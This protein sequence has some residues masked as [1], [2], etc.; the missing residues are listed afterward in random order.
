MIFFSV[1]LIEL[2]FHILNY[3]PYFIELFVSV[4]L[5]L[6]QEFITVLF[7][8]IQVF[9][10]VSFELFQHI[11]SCSLFRISPKL[12]CHWIPFPRD[13]TFERGIFSQFFLYGLYFY[14]ETGRYFLGYGL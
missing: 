13:W 4:L 5:E 14:D 12:T 3:L 1:S 8:F 6:N 11:Y 9:A 2:Y 7:N 10:H